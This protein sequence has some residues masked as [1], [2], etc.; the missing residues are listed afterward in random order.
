MYLTNIAEGQKA[1]LC[2]MGGKTNNLIGVLKKN[3]QFYVFFEKSA[4]VTEEKLIKTKKIYLK[5][6]LSI[7]D[8][9]NQFYYSLDNKT[10]TPMGGNFLTSF[11]NWKGTRVGLYSFNETSDAGSAAFNWFTYN[12]D[13]PKE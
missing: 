7:Q 4:K 12:Y 5:A 1:G 9:K 3:G 11:G 10:Y 8:Q 6:A 13:G 2:S